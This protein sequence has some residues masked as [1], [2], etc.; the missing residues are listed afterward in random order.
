MMSIAAT[1]DRAALVTVAKVG[2]VDPTKLILQLYQPTNAPLSS[3][4][5]MLDR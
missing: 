3:V 2:M 1:S 5:V 4:Q